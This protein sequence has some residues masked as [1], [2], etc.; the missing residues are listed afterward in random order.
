[1]LHIHGCGVFAAKAPMWA[2]RWWPM[3]LNDSLET[4]IRYAMYCAFYRKKEVV[5]SVCL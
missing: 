4:C 1:M 5:L 2:V 3:E